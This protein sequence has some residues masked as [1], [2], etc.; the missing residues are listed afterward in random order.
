[1][2]NWHILQKIEDFKK[3]EDLK[4]RFAKRETS[5]ET[6]IIQLKK[7]YQQQPELDY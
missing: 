6:F 4:I 1:M 7:L 2:K 5:E 3:I